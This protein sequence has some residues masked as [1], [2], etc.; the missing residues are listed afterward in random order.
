MKY[1]KLL[2][3]FII[4]ILSGC[5][6]AKSYFHGRPDKKDIER[7][8]SHKIQASDNCFTFEKSEKDYGDIIKFND[9]TTDLPRF[10]TL[11]QFVK[12]HNVRSFMLIQNDS[13][14]FEYYDEK[15]NPNSL[16]TSYSV[17]KT[18]TSTLIG[19][20]IEDGLIDSEQDLVSKYIPE[21]EIPELGKTLNIEHLLNQTSGIKFTWKQDAH[22]YYGNDISKA[23]PEIK[24]ENKPGTEQHYLNMT[25]QL[26]GI[27][28]ERITGKSVSEYLQEKIWQPIGMCSD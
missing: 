13:I 28:L 5:F 3:I 22:I 9:W 6:P 17:A 15:L 19:M 10:H 27:I 26:L 8:P 2:S 20:A 7:F 4:L 25:Y 18:F 11:N 1:F 23:I 14:K 24:F 12:E 21:W 16:H